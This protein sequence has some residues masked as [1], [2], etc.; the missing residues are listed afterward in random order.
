MRKIAM[1]AGLV[2]LM[3]VLFAPVALAMAHQCA[4]RPCTG[5]NS[6][7]T[8]YERP[9]NGT[10]DAIYGRGGRDILRADPYTRDRDRLYGNRG[11][12]RLNAHDGDTRDSVSGGP[13]FDVCIVDSRGEI[14]GSCEAVRVR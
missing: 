10:P 9:G 6:A 1:L 3:T 11:K 13:G 2:T 4:G 5:T 12:D 14:G 7:N 8:L